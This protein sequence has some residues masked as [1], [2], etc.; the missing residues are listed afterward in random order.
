[1]KV[2]GVIDVRGGQAVHARMGLRDRYEP[3]QRAA[4]APIA[5]GDAA[6]LAWS[7]VRSLGITE[8]YAADLDAIRG[9]APN[10][11]VVHTLAAIRPLWLDAGI[12]TVE[13]AARAHTLGAHRLI[14]GLETLPSFHALR[15]ICDA[16]PGAV[17]FSLDLRNGAPLGARGGLNAF[18]RPE[19]IAKRAMEAGATAVIVID[20]A[21]V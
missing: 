13:D 18:A 2:L 7:Y 9:G 14:V 20:L 10:D 5:P 16:F 3:V 12:S 6:G 19:D 17:A 4:A 1:M 8:L 15:A 21:R 11:A